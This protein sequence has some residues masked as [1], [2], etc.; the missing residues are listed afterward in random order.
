M[1]AEATT[2]SPAE[3]KHAMDINIADMPELVPRQR[4]AP[5]S[6]ASRFSNIETVGL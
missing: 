4:C 3:T 1:A 6:V 5:S 2:R